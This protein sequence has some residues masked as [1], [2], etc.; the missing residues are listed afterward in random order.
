VCARCGG[1]HCKARAQTRVRVRSRRPCT[2][3]STGRHRYIAGCPWYRLDWV[4]RS[5]RRVV[6]GME[7]VECGAWPRQSTTEGR[8]VSAKGSLVSRHG[9]VWDGL[10]HNPCHLMYLYLRVVRGATGLDRW[11]AAQDRCGR[12][13]GSGES[14]GCMYPHR[15]AL[16]VLRTSMFG[17]F[18]ARDEASQVNASGSRGSGAE[19]MR[20]GSGAGS[21]RGRVGRWV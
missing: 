5:A 2:P 17:P 12:Y 18:S 4:Q 8:V 21:L 3:T 7:G 9:A 6:A 20:N 15:P 13:L 19:A 16:S 14:V 10:I 11:H 1:S